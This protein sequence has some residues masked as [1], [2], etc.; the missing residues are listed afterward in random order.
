MT[1]ASTFD[2]EVIVTSQRALFGMRAA[3]E[4]FSVG[5]ERRAAFSCFF[6][7][8]KAPCRCLLAARALTLQTF[9]FVC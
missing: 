7:A 5:T 4:S 1:R 3:G 9:D 2:T 6:L 8:V